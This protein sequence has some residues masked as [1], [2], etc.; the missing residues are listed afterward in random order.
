MWTQTKRKKNQI[1]TFFSKFPYF[2]V[3]L[4]Q[5]CHQEPNF[6]VQEDQLP[7][8]RLWQVQFDN[9][10]EPKYDEDNW[11]PHS[12]QRDW[13][14][15]LQQYYDEE[16][17]LPHL[18]EEFLFQWLLEWDPTVDQ[19]MS[20]Y[21]SNTRQFHPHNSHLSINSSKKNK[22]NRVNELSIF[23]WLCGRKKM[24]PWCLYFC[25]QIHRGQEQC[26]FLCH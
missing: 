6:W 12:S 11:I 18:S 23:D 9:K 1:K 7:T 16:E 25:Q 3:E 4:V 26:P 15:S 13:W 20:K 14:F 10:W 17:S 5:L 24:T 21:K 2:E 8:A 19:T 22:Q